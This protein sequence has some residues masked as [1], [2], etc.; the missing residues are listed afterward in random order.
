MGVSTNAQI[1]YGILFDEDF[2]FPWNGGE[3]GGGFDDLIEWWE[4]T[5]T[6]PVPVTLV[7]CQ[8]SDIPRY[9]LAIPKT[10]LRA[11]RGCP[12][13]FT[14]MNLH[15]IDPIPMNKILFDFCNFANIDIPG[16]PSWYLSSYSDF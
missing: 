12:T 4:K 9:I 7:N 3:Y 1:C 8:H 10:S 6:T 14:P 11:L 16:A 13:I 15:E 2:E 5:N